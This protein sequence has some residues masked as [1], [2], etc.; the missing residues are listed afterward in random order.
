MHIGHSC[1]S[2]IIIGANRSM[3]AVFVWAV[4]S[5]LSSRASIVL[6]IPYLYTY[7][8]LQAPPNYVI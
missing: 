4:E 5:K 2:E 3:S 8:M 1:L 6:M 7:N